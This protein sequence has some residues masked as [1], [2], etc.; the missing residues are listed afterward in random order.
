MSLMIIILATLAAGIG[1]V[2]IAYLLVARTRASNGQTSYAQQGFLGLAAGALLTTSL[3]HLLPEALESNVDAH[4]LFLVILAGLV[5]FFLLGKAELWHHPHDHEHT[6]PSH[7]GSSWALLIGDGVHCFGD[8]VLIASM[9]IVDIR[10]GAI[11]AASV[12]AHEIPH[13]MGDLAVLREGSYRGSAVLKLTMAGGM[14]ALGGVSGY[15]LL[16]KLQH[17]QPFLMAVAGSSFIYVA[18]SDVIPRMQQRRTAKDATIQVAWL[19]LGIAIVAVVN[20]LSHGN[21]AL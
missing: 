7:R 20:S 3:T 16:E 2:W 1:S 18:L 17:W 19:L 4:E 9:F 15:L 13:H 10:L 21:S 8:G 6:S 5:F 11:A 12:S 14:T